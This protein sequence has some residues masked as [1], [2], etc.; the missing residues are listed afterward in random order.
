MSSSSRLRNLSQIVNCIEQTARVVFN[1]RP[2]AVY[3]DPLN[4]NTDNLY[5]CDRNQKTSPYLKRFQQQTG[6]SQSDK[7][8]RLT[9]MPAVGIRFFKNEILNFIFI[10]TNFKFL[11]YSF[12]IR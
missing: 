3:N 11:F 6:Q 7:N 4:Q 2:L 9:N 10:L 12:T 5:Q 1:A 8:C